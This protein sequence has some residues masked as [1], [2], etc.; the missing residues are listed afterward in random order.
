MTILGCCEWC[1]GGPLVLIGLLTAL[2]L[3]WAAHHRPAMHYRVGYDATHP[4]PNVTPR[5]LAPEEYDAHFRTV[6]GIWTPNPMRET[7]IVARPLGW[8]GQPR[9]EYDL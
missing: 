3:G 2:R 6:R 5:I 8:D 4:L 1:L 9:K 7:L